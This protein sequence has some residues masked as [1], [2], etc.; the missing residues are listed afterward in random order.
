[1]EAMFM[2]EKLSS[3]DPKIKYGAAKALLAAAKDD[4]TSLY[5]HTD[6]FVQLLDSEN[7]I[8]K[9]T[10]IDIIGLLA[11]VDSANRISA[12]TGRLVSFLSAGNLITAN[13][14]ISA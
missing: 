1:M 8:L 4:P 13:H 3:R 9:W 5:P 11:R 7:N 2:F 12:M 10:A 6:Y 14:A